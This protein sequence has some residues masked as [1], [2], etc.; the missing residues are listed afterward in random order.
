MQKGCF[1]VLEGVEGTGKGTLSLYLQQELE[2][3]NFKVFATREPGGKN[4]VV[5]EKIR[6]IILDKNSNVLPL[7]EAYLFAASRA[8][9]LREIIIPHLNKGEIVISERYVYASYAYQGEGRGLGIE[10]I[11]KL[12]TLAIDNIIPDLVIYLDLDPKIGLERKFKARQDLDRMDRETIDFYNKV[13]NAYLK[14]AKENPSLIKMVDASKPL[15]EVKQR[16]LDL[17]L[18][19]INKN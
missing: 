8:Q 7:T 9:H 16:V 3:R 18:E 19:K 1:I 5:A 6:E 17:I 4:C 10:N 15:E 11:K 13:R 2:A 12:N 14:F